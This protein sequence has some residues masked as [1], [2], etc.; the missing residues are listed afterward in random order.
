M[1]LLGFFFTFKA[2][3]LQNNNNASVFNLTFNF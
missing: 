3:S 2:Q 1:L